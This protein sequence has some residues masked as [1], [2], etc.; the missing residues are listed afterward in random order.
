MIKKALSSIANLW[1]LIKYK[2]WLKIQKDKLYVN[3]MN[4]DRY[5]SDKCICGSNKK[6]RK[7]CGK[8][9]MI[10]KT[11]L[12]AQTEMR[13][14]A[15]ERIRLELEKKGLKPEDMKVTKIKGRKRR[16]A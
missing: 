7:C 10:T 16:K 6:V 1:V 3:P 12:L 11:E 8:K 13:D 15:R 4:R 14:K 5:R 9:E 2:I